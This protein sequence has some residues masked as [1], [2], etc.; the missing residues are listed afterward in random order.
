MSQSSGGPGGSGSTA[1]PKCNIS[2]TM[3][4]AS[5]QLTV[6]TTSLA[7][8]NP[9][10]VYPALPMIIPKV[11]SEV[12]EVEIKPLNIFHVGQQGT[13]S[14]PVGPSYVP[15]TTIGSPMSSLMP[16]AVTGGSTVAK[17]LP[18]K[19]EPVLLPT[20]FDKIT[21]IAPLPAPTVKQESPVLSISYDRDRILTFLTDYWKSKNLQQVTEAQQQTAGI[22]GVATSDFCP[23]PQRIVEEALFDLFIEHPMVRNLPSIY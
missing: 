23:A 15:V 4:G 11:E 12:P 17:G 20:S 2:V 16:T 3:N 7:S 9:V 6:I 21:G 5:E 1:Y 13:S 22:S 10:G 19:Q 8:S 14:V 18:V